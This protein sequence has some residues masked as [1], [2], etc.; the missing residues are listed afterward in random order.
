MVKRG[1]VYWVNLD[2]TLGNEDQK[3]ATGSRCFI[4]RHEP[5]VAARDRSAN[6][7]QGPGVGLP[8]ANQSEGQARLRLLDR[9]RCVDKTRLAG[10][11]EAL[12]IAL[13]HPVLMETFA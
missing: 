2:P 5:G 3:D 8:A 4:R 13:W 9:I 1:E 7:Q 6:H 12:D 10:K 11:L